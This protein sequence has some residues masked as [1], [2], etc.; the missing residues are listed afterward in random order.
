[1][2]RRFIR[3]G[4]T[5]VKFSPTIPAD[6]AA[7]TRVEIDAAADLTTETADVSGFQTT[8]GK[9]TTPDMASKSETE[10]VGIR[11]P[12]DSSLTFYAD[13]DGASA[14]TVL[15]EDQVGVIYMLKEGD[16]AGRLMDVFPVEVASVGDE[17]AMGSTPARFQVNFAINGQWRKDVPVPA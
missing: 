15:P 2:A 3:Q 12:G 5:V 17:Y 10:A 13:L 4:V 1:M 9:V 7:P 14:R 16:V 6:V 8:A 11:S